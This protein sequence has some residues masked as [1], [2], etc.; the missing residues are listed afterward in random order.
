MSKPSKSPAHPYEPEPY[1]ILEA[2]PDFW[3]MDEMEKAALEE[4]LA[5]KYGGQGIRPRPERER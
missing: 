3:W 4:A 5:R 2:W 1:P